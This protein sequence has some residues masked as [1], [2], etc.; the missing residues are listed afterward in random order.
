MVFP[1]DSSARWGKI[2]FLPPIHGEAAGGIAET[3]RESIK[4]VDFS[5]L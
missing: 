5:D 4:L 1:S 3:I 2:A